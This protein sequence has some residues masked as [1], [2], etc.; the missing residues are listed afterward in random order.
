MQPDIPRRKAYVEDI[1]D[2]TRWDAFEPRPG[3]IVVTTPPKSGTTWTQSILAMLIAG[4]P[5][6]DADTAYKSPWI[7]ISVRS[8][9]EVMERLAAQEH[10]RQVKTHTPFDGIPYWSGLRYISV[11][12]HPIDVHFSFR[13]H[14]ANM[15]IEALNPFFPE[16]VEESFAYFF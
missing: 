4:D 15:A 14:N 16:D 13:K 10:R 8:V 6:T 11:Y 3:D 9:E 1:S 12:R 2:S 5:A 7:D